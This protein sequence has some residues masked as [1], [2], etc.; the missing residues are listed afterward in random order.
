MET[1]SK[2]FVRSLWRIKEVE[3]RD[4]PA[5]G[6]SGGILVLRKKDLF[7]CVETLARMLGNSILTVNSAFIVG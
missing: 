5:Y 6:N 2:G 4:L 7:E 1:L 3:W